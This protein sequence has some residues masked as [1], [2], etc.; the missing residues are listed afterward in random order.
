MDELGTVAAQH[1]V[2]ARMA[3][4]NLIPEHVT[5]AHAQRVFGRYGTIVSISFSRDKDG[6]KTVIVQYKYSRQ[7]KRAI[8]ALQR[9]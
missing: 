4:F 3:Q 9:R 5:R 1:V 7:V 2:C 6:R 8:T